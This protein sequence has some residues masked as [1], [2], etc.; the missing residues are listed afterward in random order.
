MKIKEI[1]KKYGEEIRFT[2]R[3]LSLGIL[4]I[5]LILVNQ[6]HNSAYSSGFMSITIYINRFGESQVEH[7]FYL[8]VMFACL[9]MLFLDALYGYLK[10]D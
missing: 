6:L 4:V 8:P 7:W 3:L 1:I 5:P 9:F 10:E 2:G